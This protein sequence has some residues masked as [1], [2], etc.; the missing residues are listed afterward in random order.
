MLRPLVFLLAVSAAAQ[1]PATLQ[2]LSDSSQVLV[3]RTLQFRA[4]VR[5]AGGINCRTRWLR[6][7]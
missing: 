3:G 4:V 6:G 2:V 7:R 5:D 1:T